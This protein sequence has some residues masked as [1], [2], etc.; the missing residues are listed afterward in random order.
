MARIRRKRNAPKGSTREKGDIAERVVASMHME[1][2]VK[3]ETNVYLPTKNKKGKPREIDVLITSQVA[4]IP[5]QI[6][7]ECKN[8]IEVTGVEKI[9]AFIGKLG[10]V[11]LSTQLSVYAS[12]SRY[13]VGAIERAKEVGMKT[14]LLKDVD[15]K[16]DQVINEVFQ[17]LIY[18]LATVTTVQLSLSKDSPEPLNGPSLFF[19]NEEGRIC[20]SIGDLVWDYWRQG[21]IPEQL[22]THEIQLDLPKTWKQK[23]DDQE[24]AFAQ[25]FAK[26]LVTGHVLTVTAAT[27]QH[28][29]IDASDKTLK[30]WQVEAKFPS[31]VGKHTV[32]AFQ[33]EEELENYFVSR[34]GV[35]LVSGRLKLPRIRWGASYWPPSPKALVKLQSL[36]DDA[37][38]EGKE[39]DW[40][41]FPFDEIEGTDLSAAY[42]PIW[43]GHPYET[44]ESNE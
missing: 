38:T 2:G 13:T 29:L 9:D 17:S 8:E 32:I 11:G 4:G 30:K 42:E 6:A 44:D 35:T 5:I 39:F 3:V 41:I 7:I 43:E 20:G 40:K 18:L 24:L 23:Y 21:K 14:L 36:I 1:P 37:I 26:V 12:T 19:Y 28:N 16:I 33:G 27:Q 10:H 15:N 34:K 22:G 25:I 31:P